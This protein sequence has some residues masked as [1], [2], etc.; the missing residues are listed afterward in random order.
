MWFW[1]CAMLHSAESWLR[2]ML[3]SAESWLSAM[4][5]SEEFYFQQILKNAVL[6]CIAQSQLRNMQ[7]SAESW[8]RTMQL[9]SWFMNISYCIILLVLFRD[10]HLWI[11][12]FNMLIKNFWESFPDFIGDSAMQS[13]LSAMQHSA[14]STNIRNLL[15]AKSKQN[16][17]IF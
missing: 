17:K 10:V 12:F 1:L 8:L 3:H 13:W 14:E 2:A 16:S 15:S 6:C 9:F 7:H 5:H 4:L 11:I